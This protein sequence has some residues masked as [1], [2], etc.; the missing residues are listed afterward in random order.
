MDDIFRSIHKLT[1]DDCDFEEL[2]MNDIISI[3]KCYIHMLQGNEFNLQLSDDPMYS[4]IEKEYLS[5]FIKTHYIPVI[6]TR[7]HITDKNLLDSV[8]DYYLRINYL[9]D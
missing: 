2:M 5:E 6:S 4:Y 3:E 9:E 8:V 7:I 1:I